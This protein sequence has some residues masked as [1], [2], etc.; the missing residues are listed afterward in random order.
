MDKYR[1]YFREQKREQKIGLERVKEREIGK[2]SH[3]SG[4]DNCIDGCNVIS[5]M[6]KNSSPKKK[7]DC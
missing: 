3:I 4:L 6:E 7:K 2:P 5:E 1:F